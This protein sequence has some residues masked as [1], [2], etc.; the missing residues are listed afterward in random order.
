MHAPH[1]P[2]DLEREILRD[3]ARACRLE[4]D[5]LTLAEIAELD[6]RVDRDAVDRA[7][8]EEFARRLIALICKPA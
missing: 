7:I 3:F 6:R 5:R 1:L 4:R 8:A 2:G